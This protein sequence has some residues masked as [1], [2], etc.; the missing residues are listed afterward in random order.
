MPGV[1]SASATITTKDRAIGVVPSYVTGPGSRACGAC[2]RAQM[3]KEDMA[4]HLVAFNEHAHTNGTLLPA[5]TGVFDAAVA[6]IMALF[7]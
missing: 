6:K 4:S 1:L 2:H 7:K 5:T 3:I